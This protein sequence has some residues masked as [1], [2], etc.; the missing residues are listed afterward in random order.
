MKRFSLLLISLCLLLLLFPTSALATPTFDQAVD[1]LLAKGYPQFIEEYLCSLGTNPD[2]GQRWGGSSADDEAARFIAKQMNAIGLKNV[3]LEPVPIDEFEYTHADVT[4][5]DTVLPATG[6]MG[7]RGTPPGGITAPVVYV[8]QGTGKEFDAAEAAWGPV[9]GKLVLIDK[10]MSW[11]WYNLPAEEAWIRGAQG[12]MFTWSEADPFYYGIDGDALGCFE[13]YYEYDSVPFCYISRNSGDWLKAQL[14]GPVTARMTINTEVRL[15]KDGGLGYNVVGE[16]GGT[17]KDGQQV[18]IDAHHDCFFR[19]A[20]DDTGACT[21]LLTVAKAMRISGY[22]PKHT[23]VFLATTSEEGGRTNAY[24]DWCTGAWWAATRAHPDWAGRT[25]GFIALELMAGFDA[26]LKAQP[27]PDLKP[28]VTKLFSDNAGILPHG[29]TVSGMST[30]NDQYVFTAMGT[31]SVTF[32][33]P[34]ADYMLRYHTNRETMDY[35]DYDNLGQ[36]AKFIYR[37]ARGFDT[38]LLPY[39]LNARA[40]ELASKVDAGRLI[41]AGADANLVDRFVEDV[42]AFQ[43]AAEAYDAGA[44]SIPA[45]DVAAANKTLLAV[46]KTLDNTFSAVSPLWDPVIYPHEQVLGD[47]EGVKAAIRA[48]QQPT[49]DADTA[50]G[51]LTWTYITFYGVNFSYPVYQ[52]EMRHHDPTYYN[53]LWG[54]LAQLPAPLDVMPEYRMIEAGNYDGAITGLQLKL[55]PQVRQLNGRL[56]KMADALEAVT[57]HIEGLL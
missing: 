3:R 20:M 34:D 23:L 46:T 24:Y 44:A 2:Q 17:S 4:V 39:S 7:V 32:S 6:F 36:V 41:D 29:S 43:T 57:P 55:D 19:A 28:Y 14:P 31:P 51:A 8:G 1:K 52:L 27:S 49:P 42:G 13:G 16:L 38:G 15:A 50:L 37:T 45:S 54:E 26:P 12:V 10:A 47:T 53:I 48:L 30:W 35:M 5:G 22:K 21:N 25:R 9:T 40:T 18:V 33:A 11:W 56:A